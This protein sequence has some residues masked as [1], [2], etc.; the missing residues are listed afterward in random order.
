MHRF[1]IGGRQ[2]EVEVGPRSGSSVQVTVNGKA[3]Q[4]EVAGAAPAPA[5]SLPASPQT[6]GPPPLAASPAAAAGEV[7]APIPGVVLNVFVGPGQQVTERSKLLVIEAMKME[8]E[9]F[10][11]F[12][13]VV[14]SVSVRPQQEV[15]QGDVLVKI[16]AG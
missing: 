6:G 5:A 1:T 2:Y 4:V 9:I 16:K 12:A 7:R 11:G 13:G 14:E 3:Y 10:A 15:R 8:N